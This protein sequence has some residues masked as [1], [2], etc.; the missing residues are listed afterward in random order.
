[1]ACAVWAP[2]SSLESRF[3]RWL[4]CPFT[5]DASPV[6]TANAADSPLGLPRGSVV[7]SPA[8]PPPTTAQHDSERHGQ[9]G[10]PRAPL[11]Q[12]RTVKRARTRRRDYMPQQQQACHRRRRPA[13]TWRR[14]QR[15]RFIKPNRPEGGKTP[16]CG[17]EATQ[18]VFAIPRVPQGRRGER[19]RDKTFHSSSP[20]TFTS[21]ISRSPGHAAAHQLPQRRRRLRARISDAGCRVDICPRQKAF[22]SFHGTRA[23]RCGGGTAQREQVAIND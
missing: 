9:T 5:T 17:G 6:D 3:H 19:E 22:R 13:D 10:G 7:T 1:M 23:Q 2:W 12:Q 14:K 18:L 15:P 16:A 20:S 11:T 8:R 4:R 21:R